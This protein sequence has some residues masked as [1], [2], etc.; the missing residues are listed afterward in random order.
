M[1]D[2]YAC[3]DAHAYVDNSLTPE[4]RLAFETAMRRDAKLKA[5][6]EAWEAQNDSIRLAFGGAPRPRHA[7]PLG[8][9]SNENSSLA[10]V[11]APALR[12]RSSLN[13]R[14]RRAPAPRWRRSALAGLVLVCGLSGFGGGP[15]DPRPAMMRRAETTLRAVADARPDFASDDPGAVSRWLAARFVRIDSGRL[16]RV[17]WSLLGARIVAGAH[18]AAA[19]V[20]FEDALGGRAELL[21]EPS[22]ARAT[23]P[24]LVHA[25]ADETVIAGV[26]DGFS[27]AVVGPTR[28]GVDALTPD[29]SPP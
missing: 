4:E 22:D 9:P 28:S 24:P 25:D 27:Y 16:R 20:L 15:G 21:V 14:P 13:L 7:P 3:L 11:A 8:R 23:L 12:P 5:R 2:G 26:A 18:S 29:Q 10:R 1:S 17:G 19:L 6:V